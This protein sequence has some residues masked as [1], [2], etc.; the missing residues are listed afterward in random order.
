[1]PYNA[2]A[3]LNPQR[4]EDLSGF[5][6]TVP[7]IPEP[8]LVLSAIIGDTL[9]NLR[10]ALDYLVYALASH[11]SGHPQEWTQ[12]PIDFKPEVFRSRYDPKSGRRCYLRGVS[13]DHIAEIEK[14]QPYNGC[15]WTE[16]LVELSNPDKHRRLTVVQPK[17][18]SMQLEFRVGP[19]TGF[20]GEV[21]GTVTGAVDPVSGEWVQVRHDITLGIAF[22]NGQ[23]VG[24]T[25]DHLQGEVTATLSRFRREF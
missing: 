1:M 20:S 25:L 2:E 4:P 9:Y 8:P 13:A 6:I 22:E 16:R 5:S 12:F 23:Q 24:S 15:Q 21:T 11:D 3:N 14:L 7:D 10:S 18:A 19:T 17:I